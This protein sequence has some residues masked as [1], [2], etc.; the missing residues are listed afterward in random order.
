MIMNSGV[1]EYISIID[2]GHCIYNTG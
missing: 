2:S 1:Q